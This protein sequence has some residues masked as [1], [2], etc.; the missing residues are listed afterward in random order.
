MDWKALTDWKLLV[1]LLAIAAA[2]VAGTIIVYATGGTQFVYPYLMFVPILL[3]AAWFGTV[4]AVITAIVAGLLMGPYMP[5]DTSTGEAQATHNWLVRMVFFA[6]IAAIA[7]LLFDSLRRAHVARERAARTDASSGLPNQVALHEALDRLLD[8]RFRRRTLPALFL[9]RAT[10]LNEALEAVG[11]DAADS[12]MTSLAE[13][14]RAAL[15]PGTRIYR[16]SASELA[17]VMDQQPPSLDAC[18]R[19]M[20]ETAERSVRANDIPIRLE[21]VVG[22][23]VSTPDD[24]DPRELYRRARVALF[25][26]IERQQDRCTYSPDLER[27]TGGTVALMARLRP[28]L[29]AGE[30]ELHY[31]PKIALSADGNGDR[32]VGAE[33]LIR[34]RQPDNQLVPPGAFIPKVERT[35]LINPLTR[36]VLDEVVQFARDHPGMRIGFN[37]S[38]RSLH[39]REMVEALLRTLTDAELAEGAVEIEITETALVHDPQRAVAAMHRLREAGAAISIDD[40]GTGYSS[41]AWL[42][43]MPINGLK[44]DRAF[45]QDID[46]KPRLQALV[47]CMIGVGRALELEVTAEGTETEAERETLR[48]MGCQQIQGFLISKALPVT[49]FDAWRAGYP[50]T[51]A[52]LH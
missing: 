3:A 34:W 52:A 23:A 17:I 14:L 20:H 18:A 12:I 32:I 9:A 10:D 4:G 41:F 27:D 46:R 6:G 47:G 26:A 7:G 36:F 42:R 44:I 5:L 35:R 48:Q 8:T 2:L 22:M 33:G 1:T 51:D 31:Q 29:E 28:A 25:T 30:F 11:P 24:R 39:D 45:V 13:G 16:F 21:L 50:N 43:Q 49:D 19:D 38:P 15:P 40:F 37:L